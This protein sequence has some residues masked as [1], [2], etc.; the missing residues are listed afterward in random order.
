MTAWH[1]RLRNW[2]GAQEGYCGDRTN[3]DLERAHCNEMV[4]DGTLMLN[5]VANWQRRSP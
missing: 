3:Y 5:A 4:E 2:W 1:I